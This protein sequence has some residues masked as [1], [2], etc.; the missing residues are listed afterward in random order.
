MGVMLAILIVFPGR[1]TPMALTLATGIGVPGLQAKV[2]RLEE[3]AILGQDF[4]ED[5]KA[6]LRNLYTCFAKG[7]KLTPAASVQATRSRSSACASASRV[8]RVAYCPTIPD[9]RC[10]AAFG[11]R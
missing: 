5:D 3:K 9:S 11:A 6:F 7:G 2:D 1:Q 8:Y 10:A 4:T